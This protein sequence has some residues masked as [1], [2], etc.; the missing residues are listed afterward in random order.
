MQYS[1]E[2]FQGPLD[3]LLKLMKHHEITADSIPL[4]HLCQQLG[5]AVQ[6]EAAPALNQAAQDTSHLSH[7]ASA[8]LSRLQQTQVQEEEPNLLDWLEGID[9]FAQMKQ[10]AHALFL[11]QQSTLGWFPRG[12]TLEKTTVALRLATFEDLKRHF[13]K[14]KEKKHCQNTLEHTLKPEEG[15]SLEEMI[16]QTYLELEKC[17]KIDLDVWLSQAS[18]RTCIGRFLALLELLK[19]EKIELYINEKEDQLWIFPQT[20]VKKP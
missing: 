17:Q 18:L 5:H 14:V 10:V 13:E 4:A 12:V 15:P 1:T 11:R 20:S 7:I 19:R 2:D 9:Q 16:T 3:I 6:S 8:K